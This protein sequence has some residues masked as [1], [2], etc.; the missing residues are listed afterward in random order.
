MKI[1]C[2]IICVSLPNENG[3]VLVSLEPDKVDK[4]SGTIQTLGAFEFQ[5]WSDNENVGKTVVEGLGSIK[6]GDK[7]NVTIESV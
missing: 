2:T 3:M 6:E 4:D 1:P 5:G 7:F